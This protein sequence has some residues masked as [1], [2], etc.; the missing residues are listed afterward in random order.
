M[1]LFVQ[2]SR[3][4]PIDVQTRCTEV[5]AARPTPMFAP[6]FPSAPADCRP[7]E[8]MRFP[9]FFICFNGFKQLWNFFAV[10]WNTT[11]SCF[12]LIFLIF[13][14]F[15]RCVCFYILFWFCVLLKSKLIVYCIV[16]VYYV[17]R[18]DVKFDWTLMPFVVLQPIQNFSNFGNIELL[19]FPDFWIFSRLFHFHSP[20]FV[21]CWGTEW[22]CWRICS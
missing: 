2:I 5:C 13:C 19:I 6:L 8:D 9:L 1:L 21:W 10:C 4:S 22:T 17:N 16:D 7:R 18:F 15:T 11:A 3:R 14:Y 20:Y 12:C